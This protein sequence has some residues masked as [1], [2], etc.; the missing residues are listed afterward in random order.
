M[1][2][3]VVVAT[4]AFAVSN[5]II[6][7]YAGTGVQGNTGDGG[8]ALQAKLATPTGVVLDN[9]AN[10]FVSDTGNSRVRK[11]AAGSTP[12]NQ[13]IT[14]FAGSGTYGCAGDGGPATAAQLKAPTG[15]AFYNGDVYIADSGCNKVRKVHQGTITTVAGTGSAGYAGDGGPA[16]SAKLNA[17]TAVALDSAGDLFIADTGNNVV[18][19]VRGGV[20]TTFAGKYW[21]GNY[22][23]SLS[24][25]SEH[26]DDCSLTGNGGPATSAKLCIPTGLA[27][28]GTTVLISDTGNNQ[29]RKVSGGIITAFA[30]TG[31]SGFSGDGGQAVY[32]KIAYPVGLAYDPLGDVYI[33]D[34]GNARVRQ[35]DA[36][37]KI[38]TFA[39]N[40]TF[41]AA[42][43]NGPAERAE[44]N[45]IGGVSTDAANVF[46]GDTFNNK[47]RRIHK[48]GPP[49]ALSEGSTIALAGSVAI[50][51]AGGAFIVGRRRRRKVA[52]TPA[53]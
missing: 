33:V 45:S 51:L 17:P 18:R 13:T 28:S 23:Y 46:L 22:H 34:A 8:P 29:V 12:T 32:A 16:T 1:A 10:V 2:T 43:D 52:V 19:E 24:S 50:V 5:N 30:G 21:N 3:V 31:S 15:V 14:A 47:V 41:G 40:G 38:T 44:I 20:I 48:G 26:E 6:V 9:A 11:I 7:T 35:V 27:V 42:G 37:G 4:P 39:G 49:P 36:S 25:A 53:V